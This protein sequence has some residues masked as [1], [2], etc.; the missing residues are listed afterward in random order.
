MSVGGGKFVTGSVLE[1]DKEE[2]V[3]KEGSQDNAAPQAE[4]DPRTLYERLREQ[5]QIKED[6]FAEANRLS[7]FIKRVD[8]D[9]AEYFTTLSEVQKKLEQERKEKEL[10]ELENYRKAV[11]LARITPSTEPLAAAIPS[12]A[13][14][15]VKKPTTGAKR[16][17][18]KNALDGLVVVKKKKSTEDEADER[19]KSPT[20]EEKPT[21]K[22]QDK[23]K[24]SPTNPG[25]ATATKNTTSTNTLSS[26]LAYSDDSS[27][28]EE[29]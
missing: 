18:S 11:E 26:L 10:E 2:S 8:A 16:K 24:P 14:P 25:T 1:N 29:E 3:K 23:S 19:E 6:Q 20:K 13:A 17:S 5:R 28:D 4:Y 27:S 22:K 21:A 12:M 7:N 9:E 15:T